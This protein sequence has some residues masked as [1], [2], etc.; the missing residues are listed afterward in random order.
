MIQEFGMSSQPHVHVLR[1]GG[2]YRKFI[3]FFNAFVK[4]SR[5]FRLGSNNIEVA[6]SALNE[7]RMSYSFLFLRLLAYSTKLQFCMSSETSNFSAAS[8]AGK[9]RGNVPQEYE[10]ANL[11]Q[12][13]KNPHYSWD[14]TMP[15][16]QRKG[17]RC[18]DDGLLETIHWE[19]LGLRGSLNWEYL[20]R[21]LT[22][23][24]VTFSKLTGELE[25]GNLP[26][27][28]ESLFVNDNELTG[29]PDLTSLPQNLDVLGLSNNLFHG[30]LDFSKMPHSLRILWLQN[31]AEL[32][33]TLEE[34]VIPK[35]TTYNMGGTKIV[36][37]N[38]KSMRELWSTEATVI[39]YLYSD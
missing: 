32:G 6:C 9:V 34:G 2:V 22:H 1:E 15:L 27:Q 10:L 20:P 28:L 25:I 29:T 36:I 23:F 38:R 21:S 18:N 12:N 39:K 8:R 11:I 31:N 5:C 19:F 37:W 7:K 35:R 24:S 14:S 3:G 30:V 16:C 33:G 13:V 17:L 26:S 4:C